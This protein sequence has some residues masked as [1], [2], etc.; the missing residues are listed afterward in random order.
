MA[1]DMSG[2]ELRRYREDRGMNQQELVSWLNERLGR[3]YDRAKISRWETGA[4]RIPQTVGT[5]LKAAT[6]PV[7]IPA[8]SGQ[9]NAPLV[10]CAANQKGGV[11]K[12]TTCVNVAWLLSREGQRVLL[13]DCDPQANATVHLGV[14]PHEREV[15]KETLTHAL[16][17]TRP[18]REFVTPVCDGAFDL[19]P[20]S[21]SLAAA[22]RELLRQPN[23]TLIL[24]A[25]LAQLAGHYDFV[26]LD[27][28]PHLGELT[29]SVLNAADQLLIPTQTEMLSLMGIPQLFETIAGVREL[30][31]PRLRILG[32]LPTMFSPRRLQ[33]EQILTEL[34][35]MAVSES[36]HLFAPV[37]R[38][39]DYAKSV[40]AGRPGLA[41]NP[42]SAGAESYQEIAA[43]L[44]SLA[45]AEVNHGA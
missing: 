19:L 25:K 22:D 40:L 44:L 42:N 16:R 8:A 15:V 29:V 10:L 2:E 5:A 11:G 9:R 1:H 34:R 31:N 28:P 4:E 21:I 18:L 24:R 36:L 37:R 30:V 14:D 13:V 35:A 43:A 6:S 32:I 23:G 20:S 7:G 27:C 26:I 41:V 12:T 3:R 33:D 17:S 38:A 39:A 45:R